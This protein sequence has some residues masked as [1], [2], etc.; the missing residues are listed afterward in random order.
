MNDTFVIWPHGPDKLN[1]FLNHLNSIQHSVHHGD[2]NRASALF[3]EDN[4]HAEL[5]F[6]GVSDRTVTKNGRFTMS[7]TVVE[8]SAN[9]VISPA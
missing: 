6:L 2:R 3:D 4:M 9:S 7:S 1:D 8:I 5:V